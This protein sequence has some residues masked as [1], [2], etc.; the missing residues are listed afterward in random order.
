MRKHILWVYSV[1]VLR[2]IF[3]LDSEQYEVHLRDTL[4]G[5]IMIEIVVARNDTIFV[6]IRERNDLI[7]SRRLAPDLGRLADLL[8][9]QC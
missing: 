1:A 3:G 5:R 7:A 9:E 4:S 8:V 2:W 6:Y